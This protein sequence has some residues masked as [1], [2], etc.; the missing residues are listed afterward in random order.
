MQPDNRFFPRTLIKS[1]ALIFLA[2][3]EATTLNTYMQQLE[4]QVKH[5]IRFICTPYHLYIIGLHCIN[6]LPPIPEALF[7][8]LV[9]RL[10]SVMKWCVR[11]GNSGTRSLLTLLSSSGASSCSSSKLE[12]R[13]FSLQNSK[14]LSIVGDMINSAPVSGESKHMCCLP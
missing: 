6:D 1:L 10:N 5:V 2:G 11:L 9:V 7:W 13:K 12:A 4:K 14:P 8:I 3:L